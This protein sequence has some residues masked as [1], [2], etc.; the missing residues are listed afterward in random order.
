MVHG[1]VGV[2]EDLL[3]RR[4]ARDGEGDADAHRDEQLALLEE[5]RPLQLGAEALGHRGDRARVL[6]VL[7]EDGELVAAEP[8]DGVLRP[9]ADGQPL[10]EA[11]E[12]LIARAV[13]EAV[14]DDLEAVEIEEQHREQ[15]AS[16]LGARQGMG[17]AID[18]ERSIGQAGERI[19]EGL[20][21]ELIEPARGTD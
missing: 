7:E 17:E 9:Q 6:H 10:A 14:V 3:G 20:P 11:D 19:A 18:E 15:L 16:A 5:E 1:E 12:Q 4:A 2:A 21:R 8:G 13:S